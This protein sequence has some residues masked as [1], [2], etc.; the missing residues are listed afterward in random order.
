VYVYAL[1]LGT[2]RARKQCG[3][4]LIYSEQL[5]PHKGELAMKRK[6]TLE[7]HLALS[8]ETGIPSLPS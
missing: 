7:E 8:K 4:S 2:P 3:C 5:T 6:I 1:Y